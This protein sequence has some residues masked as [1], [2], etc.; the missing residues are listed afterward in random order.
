MFSL[1]HTSKIAPKVLRLFFQ[2]P[3]DALVVTSVFGI[4]RRRR[5]PELAFLAGI[6]TNRDTMQWTTPCNAV[7]K[8]YRMH[9]EHDLASY[10]S[11]ETAQRGFCRTL[12]RSRQYETAGPA[13]SRK[14]LRGTLY[15]LVELKDKEMLVRHSHSI[16]GIR[17][18][19]S[20]CILPYQD[21]HF[22][23]TLLQDFILKLI[24]ACRP[25]S[26]PCL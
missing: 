16:Q 3:L 2:S 1:V 22:L 26:P 23:L 20:L 12:Y 25:A 9:C 24:P 6:G 18:S 4:H 21:F 7:P 5:R 14:N 13:H 17:F 19:R 8:V 11:S 10:M 15:I